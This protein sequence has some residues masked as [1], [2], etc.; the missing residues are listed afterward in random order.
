[1]LLSPAMGP[2]LTS[3]GPASHQPWARLADATLL[4]MY[5][6]LSMTCLTLVV[7]ANACAR[8]ASG[9]SDVTRSDVT[10]L[11]DVSPRR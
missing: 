4:D 6:S 10:H 7:V 2:P 9:L 11:T 8:S 3:P 5:T 1:M